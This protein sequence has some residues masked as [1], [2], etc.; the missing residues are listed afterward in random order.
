MRPTD[1]TSVLA[2]VKK[3]KL[4]SPYGSG[5]GLGKYKGIVFDLDGTLVNS[6]IDFPKMKRNMIAVL[7]EHGAPKGVLTTADD[8]GRH[9][10]ARGE[11]LGGA[12]EARGG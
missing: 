2:V 3:V 10:R 4:A 12:G 9:P 7:E 8:D 1:C 11:I 6:E 5:I